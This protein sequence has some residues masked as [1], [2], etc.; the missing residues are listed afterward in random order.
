MATFTY[1]R[2]IPFADN[3]PSDDQ[4]LM[5]TNTNSTDDILDVDHYSFETTNL[6][7]WHRQLTLAGRNV[8]AAQ[9]DPASVVYSDANAAS[10]S[11]N[12]NLWYRNQDGIF[13]L[14]SIR[15]VGTF[16]TVAPAGAVVVDN[17]YNIVGITKGAGSFYT[18]EL[19]ANCVTGDN[20]I[21]V[22]G[23]SNTNN[24]PTYSFS[25]PNLTITLN[26]NVPG[27]RI[28]FVVLQI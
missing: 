27:S 9:T 6:D 4:P 8:A 26:S 20:V 1:N 15:A 16:T 23:E 17:G 7:G 3:D 5:Q 22:T 19:V 11:L 13:P 12:S 21:V 25:N 2:N 10:A 14:S 28:S 18:I 24:E